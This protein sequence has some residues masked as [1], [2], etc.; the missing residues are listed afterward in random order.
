QG[1]AGGA[2]GAQELLLAV[3][4]GRIRGRRYR[5]VLLLQPGGELIGRLGDDVDGHVG[6]L[7]AAELRA[8]A[9]VGAGFVGF[10]PE[11]VCLARNDVDFTV[12][13]RHPEA[14]DDVRRGDAHLH[15]TPGREV[16]LVGS[17]GVVA[18]V[19]NLPPP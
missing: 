13:L 4:N 5:G 6:V 15:R 19:T 9:A 11:R 2:A 18:G 12:E 10:D 8:L 7:Q 1:V 3:L 14:V 16:Y 17:G